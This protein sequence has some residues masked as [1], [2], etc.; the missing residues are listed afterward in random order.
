MIS[1]INHLLLTAHIQDHERNFMKLKLNWTKQPSKKR[2][3][4]IH[5]NLNGTQSKNTYFLNIP[6]TIFK[7]N[8]DLK[9]L[10]C[11]FLKNNTL[12]LPPLPNMFENG[13][14]CLGDDIPDNIIDA[15][16]IFWNTPF[17]LSNASWQ[18]WMDCLNDLNPT[19]NFNLFEFWEHDG[20][21][22]NLGLKEIETIPRFSQEINF[23]EIITNEY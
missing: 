19:I 18:M 13:L 14:V 7:F 1:L 17:L 6:E 12:Y 20:N 10:Y 9:T 5:I 2:T 22:F 4:I 15:I 11:Y 3:V 8:V 16:N 21:I 23:G